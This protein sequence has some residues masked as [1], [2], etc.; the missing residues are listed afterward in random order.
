[1]YYSDYMYLTKQMYKTM[2]ISLEYTTI[3]V[4]LSLS[5]CKT[6]P[7][8]VLMKHSAGIMFIYWSPC[9][10]SVEWAHEMFSMLFVC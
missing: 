4:L 3:H 5:K 1:M 6:T 7:H 2:H 8:A 10:N 9:G